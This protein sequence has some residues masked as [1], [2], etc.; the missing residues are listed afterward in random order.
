MR[1]V[2]LAL[3]GVVMLSAPADAVRVRITC[4]DGVSPADV[5][6]GA[7]RSVPSPVCDRD[8]RA[9]GACTFEVRDPTCVRDC[10][11]YL[12]PTVVELRPGARRTSRTVKGA[13]HHVFRLRC[14]RP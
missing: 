13:G 3:S 14:R 2:V 5:R 6:V 9:D 1:S 4:T 7:R 11:D 10:P 12:P 8:G